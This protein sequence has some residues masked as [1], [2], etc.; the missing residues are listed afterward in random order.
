MNNQNLKILVIALF[1]LSFS[2]Y[3][4]DSLAVISKCA[5]LKAIWENKLNEWKV[6]ETNFKTLYE[7]YKS[8]NDSNIEKY[9][10]EYD[11]LLNLYN[12]RWI[13]V[14]SSNLNYLKCL[15]EKADNKN[16]NPPPPPPPP[17]KYNDSDFKIHTILESIP[18]L[19]QE[20]KIKIL[21]FL[22]QAYS[23][24]GDGVSGE[25]I[26]KFVCTK[27]GTIHSVTITKENP[28]DMGFGEAVIEAMKFAEFTP[29]KEKNRTPVNIRMSL[30]FYFYNRK[31][32]RI[33]IK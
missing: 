26:I 17:V 29:A 15:D 13:A 10:A 33:E 1:I 16:Y 23:G 14:K 24:K 20:S 6:I 3:S 28:V 27:E 4:Q 8:Y 19:T 7:K 25:V 12:Y 21:E 22:N 5:S 31:E 9:K 2:A 11:S 18:E 30:H 32:N